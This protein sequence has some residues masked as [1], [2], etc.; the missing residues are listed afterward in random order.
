MEK[1]IGDILSLSNENG[2]QIS[3]KDVGYEASARFY[4]DG[5]NLKKKA[6]SASMVVALELLLAE[7]N[8]ISESS[9]EIELMRTELGHKV[10]KVMKA[11]CDDS[12]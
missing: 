9:R 1:M 2:V 10:A 8:E 6:C 5:Y 11:K 12:V 7:L 4:F 3:R